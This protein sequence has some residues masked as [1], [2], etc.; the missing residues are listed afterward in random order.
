[1]RREQRYQRDPAMEQRAQSVAKIRKGLL[2]HRGS[3]IWIATKNNAKIAP[4]TDAIAV[5]KSI[6][7]SVTISLTP[8]PTGMQ[9]NSG[10]GDSMDR[11]LVGGSV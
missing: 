1:M 3:R 8:N 2:R 6:P 5:K 9:R 4:A 11:T 7:R 10:V